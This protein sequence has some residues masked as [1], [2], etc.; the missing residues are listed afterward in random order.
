MTSES[1]QQENLEAATAFGEWFHG[2]SQDVRLNDS[3]VLRIVQETDTFEEEV[4]DEVV[5]IPPAEQA[6]PG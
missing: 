6:P 4:T 5:I 2:I 1:K 3:V